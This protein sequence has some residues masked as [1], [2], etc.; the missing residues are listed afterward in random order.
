MKLRVEY[1]NIALYSMVCYG[2]AHQY[3]GQK[4]HHNTTNGSLDKGYSNVSVQFVKKKKWER[5]THIF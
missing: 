4:K 2:P 3:C 5:Q 1:K